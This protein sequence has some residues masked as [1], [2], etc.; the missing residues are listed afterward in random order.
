VSIKTWIPNALSF[1]RI[2]SA[3]G[4]IILLN[5]G[6][7]WSAISL[8]T[9]AVLTDF[10]DGWLARRWRVSSLFGAALDPIA[11]KVMCGLLGWYGWQCGWIP[12][13]PIM[14]LILRDIGLI[15]GAC[16]L[17]FRHLPIP[18]PVWISKTNTVLVFFSIVVSMLGQAVQ[19]D[20]ASITQTL[21][22]GVMITTLVSSL[23]YGY[24]FQKV[25]QT[26]HV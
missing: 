10:F 16:Y 26:P 21:W 11:D 17:L 4:V 6:C 22:S 24:Q 25:L 14:L 8:L 13:L 20:A 7:V 12:L 5:S 19:W 9:I 23:Q 2:L 1:L 15:V 18:S 3:F